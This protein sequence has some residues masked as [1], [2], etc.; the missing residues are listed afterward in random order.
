MQIYLEGFKGLVILFQILFPKAIF[1]KNSTSVSVST[2]NKHS[3]EIKKQP[4]AM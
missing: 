2:M 3:V 4:Q 1:Y